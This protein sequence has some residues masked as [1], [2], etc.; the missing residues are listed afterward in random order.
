MT[1]EKRIKVYFTEEEKN[2]LVIANDILNKLKIE[3]PMCFLE[4][5]CD[6]DWVYYDY[7]DEG[8]CTAFEIGE[9][10]TYYPPEDDT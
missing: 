4:S 7:D 10:N 6:D 5:V 1:I 9:K 3:N 2:A 8:E